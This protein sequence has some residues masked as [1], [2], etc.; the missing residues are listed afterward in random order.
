MNVEEILNSREI[1]FTPKGQDFVISC[2][3]PEHEDNNPSMHIDKLSG[4]FNCFSCGYKGNIFKLYNIHRNWQ[5][6]RVKQLRNKISKIQRDAHGLNMP[7]GIIPYTRTFRDISPETLHKYEAFTHKD[8][9]GRIVFPLRDITGKIRA[10][11]GRY[12][13]SNA[14]PKYLISPK[15]AELPLFPPFVKP[16]HSSIVL[17]EGSLDALNL[18]DKGLTNVVAILGANNIKE[19]KILPLKLQGVTKLYTLFDADKAG[20]EASKQ[21][22]KAFIDH[23]IIEE[24]ELPEGLDPG[25]LSKE[26]VNYIKEKLYESK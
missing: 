14:Y 22:K 11:I 23:F 6:I 21:L 19:D 9:E 12:I 13:D 17:V 26:D 5:D 24:L 25:D 15:G 3:N 1:P 20:R 18:I 2:L 4:T 8:Y 10:F 7:E 16:I